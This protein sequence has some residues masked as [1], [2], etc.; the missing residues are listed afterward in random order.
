MDGSDNGAININRKV[1]SGGAEGRLNKMAFDRIGLTRPLLGPGHPINS[2]G[3][4][5]DSQLNR[6]RPK[7]TKGNLFLHQRI[8]LIPRK[9]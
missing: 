8:R 1:M 2:S 3:E 9:G 4:E 6:A 5:I 7:S